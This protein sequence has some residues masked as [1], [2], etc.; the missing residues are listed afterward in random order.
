MD[1]HDLVTRLVRAILVVLAA[2]VVVSV[3]AACDLARSVTEFSGSIKYEKT[4]TTST[5]GV[6]ECT[7]ETSGEGT[8]DVSTVPDP[9]SRQ[10]F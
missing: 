7:S 10:V 2:L 6:L 8:S 3:L 5:T 1:V 9:D 4:C